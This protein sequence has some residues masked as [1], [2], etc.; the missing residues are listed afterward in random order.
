MDELK[1]CPSQWEHAVKLLN[2]YRNAHYTDALT[3]ESHELADAIN[4]ILPFAVWAYRRPAP[5][6]PCAEIG[7]SYPKNGSAIASGGA[8]NKRLIDADVLSDEIQHLRIFL[9]GRSIFTPTIK[10][11]IL[12]TIDEQ[13]T[14]GPAPEN[15][16]L[17]LEQLRQM[18]GEAVWLDLTEYES[19]NPFKNGLYL[20]DI[21]E[22]SPFFRSTYGLLNG[23]YA[24]CHGAKAYV[25]NA[26]TGGSELK[27]IKVVYA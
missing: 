1:P 14:V 8:R 2:A 18:D 4:G 19:E 13:P 11:T 26:G 16:P 5:E 6:N 15:K 10:E 3:E 24:L 17:T 9:A 25:R 23:S 20:V 27:K 12:R 7:T 22:D 21:R